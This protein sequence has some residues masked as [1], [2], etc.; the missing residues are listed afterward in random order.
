MAFVGNA[1]FKCPTWDKGIIQSK[2]YIKL[3]TSVT[4]KIVIIWLP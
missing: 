4:N 1:E 2:V 3:N